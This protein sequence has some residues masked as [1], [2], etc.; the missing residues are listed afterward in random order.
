MLGVD[1]EIAVQ[2]ACKM[3][4]DLSRETFEKLKEHIAQEHPEL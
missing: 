4:H 1:P 2:D 3:E